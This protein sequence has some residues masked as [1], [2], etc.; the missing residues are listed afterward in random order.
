MGSAS[1]CVREPCYSFSGPRNTKFETPAMSRSGRSTSTS[2]RLIRRTRKNFQRAGRDSRRHAARVARGYSPVWSATQAATFAQL[3]PS[4]G[5]KWP[6]NRPPVAPVSDRQIPRHAV[7]R[8]RRQHRRG[9]RVPRQRRHARLVAARDPLRAN[10]CATSCH[11]KPFRTP[12]PVTSTCRGPAR[13]AATL[14]PRRR[15]RGPRGASRCRAGR[16]SPALSCRAASNAASRKLRP[17][18]SGWTAF[19]GVRVRCGCSSQ[20]ARSGSRHRPCTAFLPPGS[21]DS[22]PR[23]PW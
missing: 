22:L 2:H 14:A 16:A 23:V 8:Q 4:P 19:G 13:P 17:N 3:R 10:C 5:A 15:S 9:R 12:P 7:A 21:V 20:R 1:S 11:R 6:S 18:A